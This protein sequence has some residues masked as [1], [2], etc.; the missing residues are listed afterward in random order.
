ML[1][2]VQI[3]A[4]P[5][6]KLEELIYEE[7]K[8]AK[9]AKLGKGAGNED[10][11]TAYK[12]LKDVAI[13]E[14]AVIQDKMGLISNNTKHSCKIVSGNSSWQKSA[15]VILKDRASD[16]DVHIRSSHME[17]VTVYSSVKAKS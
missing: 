7:R 4:M 10:R 3:K 6:S 17:S 13:E 12:Y 2:L 8:T 16:R 9:H 15:T 1:K 11:L 14:T 5:S